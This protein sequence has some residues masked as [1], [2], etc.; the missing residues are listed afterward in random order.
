MICQLV[1]C[2]YV[3][4]ILEGTE[5]VEGNQWVEVKLTVY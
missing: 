3:G 2:E 4:N 1:G 5:E